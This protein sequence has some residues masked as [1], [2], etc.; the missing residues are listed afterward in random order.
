MRMLTYKVLLLKDVE[1]C[2]VFVVLNDGI[3]NVIFH[4]GSI[5]SAI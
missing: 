3:G 2:F 1:R 4:Q 5:T